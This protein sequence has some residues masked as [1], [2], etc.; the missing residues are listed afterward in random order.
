[1]LKW[2]L[3]P[4]KELSTSELYAIMR[5]RQEVFV[6]EQ[7]CPF[8]DADYNDQPCHHLW[9]IS[10]GNEMA[11]YARIVP[12]GGIYT[13]ASIGRVVTSLKYRKAGYGKLLMQKAIEETEKIYGRN[14]IRIEAQLYLL[15]FYEGFGFVKEGEPYILD[16]ILH[17]IMLRQAK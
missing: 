16:D 2:H 8:I 10:P 3:K 12:P 6:L 15:H 4:Y 13:E 1:M 14:S 11:A 17:I 5:I 7:K 9:G